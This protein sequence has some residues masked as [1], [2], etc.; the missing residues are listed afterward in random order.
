MGYTSSY[1]Q[2]LVS[3]GVADRAITNQGW[4]YDPHTDSWAGL[5]AS[6]HVLFRGGSTCGLHRIG[7]SV[8][9]GF[10]PANSTEL[11]PTY[12]ACGS[13]DVP[14]LSL[15]RR[16]LTLAP[17]KSVKVTMRLD[18]ES[19]EPGT[20]EAAVWVKEDT[21]YLIAP[22]AVTMRATSTREACCR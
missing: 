22:I 5:P 4:I 8:R 12:G 11:L 18:A 14:W 20:H 1:D 15:D 19:I 9:S 6:S 10:V 2:L 17:G 13:E 7:G 21:P 16:S 3:G